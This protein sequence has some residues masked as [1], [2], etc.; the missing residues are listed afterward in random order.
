MDWELE[1]RRLP[2]SFALLLW[3]DDGGVTTLLDVPAGCDGA[4]VVL[5]EM[6]W[7]LTKTPWLRYKISATMA[8]V[9]ISAVMPANNAL[10]AT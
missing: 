9:R 1:G 10:L 6:G 2:V 7:Y 3:L 5:L 8:I 4:T